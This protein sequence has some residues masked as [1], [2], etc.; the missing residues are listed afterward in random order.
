MEER[1]ECL[2][3]SSFI[4]YWNIGESPD[5]DH[6]VEGAKAAYII[7]RTKLENGGNLGCILWES[8]LGH[9]YLLGEV[10]TAVPGFNRL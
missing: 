1:E 8:P 2:L 9:Y 5:L 4:H 3:C 10:P 7:D 6:P